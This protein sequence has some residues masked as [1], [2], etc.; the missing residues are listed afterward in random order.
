[1]AAGASPG[2]LPYPNRGHGLEEAVI[3]RTTRR[4]WRAIWLP[5]TLAGAAVLA[6][7]NES[8][9]DQGVVSWPPGAAG[10][11]CKYLEY[12]AVATAIGTRFDTAGGARKDDTYTCALTQS[13]HEYPDLTFS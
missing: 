1:M 10:V 2:R 7:C 8:A 11:A 6:G 3:V 13:T 12:D 4:A 9:A 5:V